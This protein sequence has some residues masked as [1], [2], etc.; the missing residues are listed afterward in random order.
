MD[1]GLKTHEIK[2]KQAGHM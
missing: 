2:L 1:Q